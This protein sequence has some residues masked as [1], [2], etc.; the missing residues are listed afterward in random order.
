MILV[1]IYLYFAANSFLRKRET[2]T[3]CAETKSKR[4]K[5]VICLQGKE[6]LEKLMLY[7]LR[8]TNGPKV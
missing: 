1:K 7:S 6:L 5:V 4:E 3:C 2:L 8:F